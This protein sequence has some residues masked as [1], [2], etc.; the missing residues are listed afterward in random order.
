MEPQV[1][2]AHARKSENTRPV[3]GSANDL[4]YYTVEP[5]KAI[6]IFTFEY[7]RF[8]PLF[9]CSRLQKEQPN[10]GGD[11]YFKREYYY[12]SGFGYDTVQIY[13]TFKI[14]LARPWV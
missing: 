8:P 1:S 11:R 2:A 3:H 12:T 6:M 9:C 5:E 7:S 13:V 14:L 4:V 10:R